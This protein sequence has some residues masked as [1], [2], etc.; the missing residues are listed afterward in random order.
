MK[1]RLTERMI[2][3]LKTTENQEDVFHT[4]TPSAGLRLTREGRKTWFI[5]YRS[6]ALLDGKGQPRLRRFYL[7]EHRTGKAGQGRYLTLEE[8]KRA[9]E[10]IRGILARGIDPQEGP[11]APVLAWT[12]SGFETPGQQCPQPVHEVSS[13]RFLP[14]EAVPKWLQ[15]VFPEGYTEGTLAHRLS[16]YFEAAKKGAGTR[17][18]APRSLNSY[19][20]A[21]KAHLVTR[22]GTRHATSITQDCIYDLFAELGTRAPQMVRQV[23]KVLSGVFEYCR[24][25]V[26]EMRR[27]PNPTLGMK[28][29]VRKAKRDRWLTDDELQ[30]LLPALERLTDSKA[31]DVYHLILASGCRPGEAAGVRAE[32][33]ITIGGER[34]WR[35]RYK[36]D[37]DHLIPLL[38]PI[39]EIINRRYAECGGKGSLFWAEVDR[40]KDYPEQLTRANRE[41]RKLTGLENYRPHDNRRT[42]R[43]HFEILG[44][45]SEVAEALLNHQ[46]GEIEGTYALYTY[47]P[48]RKEALSLWHR[49]L[50]A[51]R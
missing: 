40:T 37:R 43:T 21:A 16:E 34:V 38:G 13:G 23:K 11:G 33:I 30:I 45:R 41:I 29:H 49:K 12:S 26:R 9:Y 28:V 27:F 7:G 47:W 32:D 35:V 8:F 42:A 22:W 5:Y 39:G 4:P 10:V 19:A 24:A 6:P 36:V 14:V 17:K 20:S 48:E 46:K 25:N 31:R 15:S 1:V 51:L 50:E 18:L 44:I 2:E 3:S